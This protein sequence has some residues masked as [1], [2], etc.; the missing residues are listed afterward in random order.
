APLRRSW[1]RHD[2]RIAGVTV[3]VV[4]LAVGARIAGLGGFDAYPTVSIGA[5][6]ADL[7]L[8]VLF[9]LAGALPAAGTR[10]RL[11]VAS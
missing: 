6:P 8:A 4:G 11:G 9:A 2:V 1:S 3:L 7:T 10:A 5:G